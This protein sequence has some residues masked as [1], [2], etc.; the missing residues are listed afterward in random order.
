DHSVGG[1]MHPVHVY[2]SANLVCTSCDLVDGRLSAQQVRGCGGRD[3]AGAL[4][5]HLVEFI[6]TKFR[7]S[8]VEAEPAHGD[9]CSS[10]GLDPGT[11][12]GVV[13]ELSDDDL[14]RTPKS[15][16]GDERSRR[17]SA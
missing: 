8:R 5:Y 16:R 11:D 3:Q 7:S 9:A 4:T 12:V 15:W 6:E 13:V 2:E 17:R 14:V 10:G 1:V